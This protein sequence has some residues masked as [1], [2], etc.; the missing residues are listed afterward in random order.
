M[1]KPVPSHSQ[2]EAEAGPSRLGSPPTIGR[3]AGG[4]LFGERRTDL[5]EQR[6]GEEPDAY[7]TVRKRRSIFFN[8]RQ[9]RH[10][11]PKK[12]ASSVGRLAKE[13]TLVRVRPLVGCYR[14]LL[15]PASP[16]A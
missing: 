2:G 3:R 6:A 14:A 13:V 11:S 5:V 16:A 12:M 8:A 7:K 1:V 15:I 4:K 9:P 10:H